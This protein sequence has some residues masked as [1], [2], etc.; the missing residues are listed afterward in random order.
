M[1]TVFLRAIEADIDEK[2]MTLKASIHSAERAVSSTRFEVVSTDFAMVPR[3][4]FP[5][6]ASE[7][8]L[9]LFGSLPPLQN[10]KVAVASGGKTLDDFRWIRATWEVRAADRTG[11]HGFAKGGS[12]A[13]LYSDIHLLLDWRDNAAALKTY[14]VDYRAQRGWSPNWTAELH[15]S[16]HYF[17]PG[18]TWPR[19]TN[20]LSFRVM[21]AG[22]IFGD[23][24]PAIFVRDDNPTTLFAFSVVINSQPFG[25]LVALQLARTE[26]AQS[27]EVGLI[28][29]TPVPD[30]SPG[31]VATLARLGHRAWSL[32][33]Q[34][35]TITE[36][37]HAFT[38]PALLPT[39]GASLSAQADGWNIRV[40]DTLNAL[41]CIQADIDDRCFA[42][43][44]ISDE[45]R[46]SIERGFGAEPDAPTEEDAPD[47]LATMD[48]GPLVVQLLS[49]TM[50]A[51]F[52][53]FDVRLA[54]GE[55][56]M[57]AEPK[58]FDSLPACSPGML[59]GDDGFPLDEPPKSYPITFPKDGILVDDPGHAFHFTAAVRAV[60]D[61]VFD[62]G[63]ARWHETAELVGARKFKLRRWFARDFFPLH[64][65]TY[66][67]SRRKAPIYW[68]LATPSASYSAWVYYH[69]FSRD[70]LFRVHELADLKLQHEESKLNALIRDAG[71]EPSRDQRGE[72]STQE[73][74][75]TE[76]RAFKAEVDRVVPLWNPDLNDG[77]II[78][79]APLWRL[80]PQH[81]PWQKEVKKIWEKLVAGDYD[82]SHLAMHL[83][84]ERVVPKCQDDRSLA[85]AH[86]LE[87]D[88]WVED[89]GSRWQK[90]QI[91]VMKVRALI[92]E[93]SSS[94]VKAALDD[95]LSAP[96]PSGGTGRRKSN[97]R[98]RQTNPRPG[99]AP[100]A[101]AGDTPG[102]RDA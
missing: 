50:G 101:S 53:R 39:D 83:W 20:G 72:I 24:G 69:R 86:G 67:K 95:L 28:Q 23:K 36:T 71:T 40:T 84:P 100:R 32:K 18:L 42:L 49:W 29:R 11:W 12:F 60:F 47:E 31:D 7:Q 75:V 85:I 65:K 8:L 68:Q 14:L 54:T 70:S 91:A 82:W 87:N 76:L 63:D 97:R 33:R 3:S 27:Y 15:G 99:R 46:R 78:N 43:Y 73:T 16:D 92:A 61:V 93:R 1:K 89:D 58:P 22:C 80:V 56:A 38:L 10:E 64:I 98:K 52:G 21:P 79:F 88:F 45:D 90:R 94:A 44:G 77:V 57:P 48:P 25:A 74:F 37:S 51:A 102:E 66:S 35:D 17:R 9:G 59:T 26:L 41:D 55:R 5:Y 13:Q 2:A 6:W 30:L 81:K 96:V 4:P 19:R 34:L 62:D